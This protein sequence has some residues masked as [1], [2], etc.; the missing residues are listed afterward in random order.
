MTIPNLE[1]II[2]KA[3]NDDGWTCEAHEPQDFGECTR[4]RD[5]QLHTA[6][7]V[8]AA[9]RDSGLTVIALP[10]AD[11]PDARTDGE[12][13]LDQF[14]RLAGAMNL[15]PDDG[16]WHSDDVIDDAAAQVAE[17]KNNP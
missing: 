6:A 16:V 14:V 4:C 9:I 1:Q 2:A 13:W 17:R 12:Y 8:V 11:G 7:H 10:D 3:I 15:I 5:S